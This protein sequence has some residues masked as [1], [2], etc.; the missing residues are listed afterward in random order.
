MVA[1]GDD[2]DLDGGDDGRCWSLEVKRLVR[3]KLM[4]SLGD[5][6]WMLS[7]I[8]AAAVDAG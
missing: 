1:I 2:D 4:R 8:V 3:S 7:D 5:Q 6:K